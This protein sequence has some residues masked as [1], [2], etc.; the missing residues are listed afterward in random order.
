M[1]GS[2]EENATPYHANRVSVSNRIAT[3]I[4]KISLSNRQI[5]AIDSV[6]L[7]KSRVGKIHDCQW[8]I[9]SNKER[10]ETIHDTR[11]TNWLGFSEISTQMQI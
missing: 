1:N 8:A 7:R 9:G 2:C 5:E 4:S 3:F 6:V 11:E 10:R